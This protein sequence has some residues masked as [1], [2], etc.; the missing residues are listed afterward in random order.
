MPR[1]GQVKT[2]IQKIGGQDADQMM[3]MFNQM[4]GTERPEF[5]VVKPKLEKLC[6]VLNSVQTLLS[7]F[8]QSDIRKGF[9][10][11]NKHFDEITTF[12]ESISKTLTDYNLPTA[13]SDMSDV[14][15]W[16]EYMNKTV[17]NYLAVKD[18]PIV[19]KLVILC[20][21]LKK[22]K[23][24]IGNREKLSKEFIVTS[25][26][27]DVFML[28]PIC[29]LPF[30][31][32]FI[33]EKIKRM[34]NAEQYIL[35]LLCMLFE[36]TFEVYKTIT[37]PDVD[38]DKFVDIVTTS[39]DQVKK[40]IPQCDAAFNKI[41]NATSMLKDNFDVYYKDFITNQNPTSIMED[42][43]L[44]VSRTVNGDIKMVAQFNKIINFYK[45]K[46]KAQM[47]NNPQLKKVFDVVGNQLKALESMNDD[48]SKKK[49]KSKDTDQDDQED[50][51]NQDDVEE[52]HD[53][54][55]ADDQDK[56][57]NQDD[58][59]VDEIDEHEPVAQSTRSTAST[60]TKSDDD[61]FIPS[62]SSKSKK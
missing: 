19:K 37:S 6:K 44:D 48:S 12:I 22:Q 25:V 56:E 40:Q 13:P 50:Q 26:D 51:D 52:E 14:N 17:D 33:G 35:L 9:P 20:R 58:E 62:K 31:D 55:D 24:Y 11:H 10:E 2:K 15:G 21:E 3:G 46:S 18:C 41:K 32:I 1:G 54:D 4:L 30:K 43:V 36:K 61:D 39:I 57:Q 16:K 59:E 28:D 29:R 42:F 47:Q 38:V 8:N 53:K 60:S 45:S 23:K 7:K 27:P 5:S 34:K 49:K